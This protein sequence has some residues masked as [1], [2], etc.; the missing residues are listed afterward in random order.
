MQNSAAFI[1][2]AFVALGLSLAGWFGARAL[3]SAKRT[4]RY[5]SVKGLA[6]REVPADLAIWPIKFVVS[7]NELG[8]LQSKLQETRAV[9]RTFLKSSGFEDAEITVVPPEISDVR[10]RRLDE[11]KAPPTNR[12]EAEARVLLRTT[13]VDAVVAAL[14]ESD[15][16]VKQGIVMRGNDEYRSKVEFLFNGINAIKPAMIEEATRNARKAAEQFAKDSAS[17]V[18][19]IR[20]ATQGAVQINDRDS[21]SPQRK[22]VRVVTTVDYFVD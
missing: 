3:E 5:V 18:G 1:L 10:G 15:K 13:K 20:H 16:L 12:Y 22:I 2:G 4:D 17:R 9:I 8:P 6:E 14:S 11:E 19:A 7:D 21:S